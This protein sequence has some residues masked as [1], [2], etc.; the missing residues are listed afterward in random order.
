MF[1]NLYLIFII[2]GEFMEQIVKYIQEIVNIH[3][4]S[5][6]TE[7]INEYLIN[8]ATQYNINYQQTNKGALIMTNHEKPELIISAHV[9]TL[10]AMVSEILID[11]SLRI[12][13]IGGLVLPSFEGE[14]VTIFTLDNKQFRGTL[15]L[16]NSSPH[17]NKNANVEER[18]YSNM[19]IRLDT[20]SF[21][22]QDI[23][24]LGINIGDYV[25]FD[26]R[27]EY[28]E[29][30]FIKSH[31]LDDKAS[32]AILLDLITELG[33]KQLTKIPVAFFFSNY[34]ELGYGA[35]Y[36]IPASCNE[37]LVIDM[38][39]IGTNI[40]GHETKVSICVKDSFGPYDYNMRKI[41]IN[42][43][44]REQISYVLDVFPYYASDAKAALVAGL[45][46]KTAL[47]G[48]GI[49]ASHGMERTHLKGLI[50]TKDLIKHYILYRFLIS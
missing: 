38:G 43:A 14:Y 26:T 15:L 8:F 42:L 44:K 24:N 18:K 10:G 31:F 17:A 34:E 22:K 12:S 35:S 29:T 2:L 13:G 20:E 45:D 49:S 3:S 7:K 6:F 27:F 21:N 48:P 32:V 50:S 46:L 16:D 19:Y 36:G 47:I 40:S 37:L 28:T 33:V 25:C 4:P 5:G 1:V 30:G 41:L 23:Q 39:V 9:D 11:G